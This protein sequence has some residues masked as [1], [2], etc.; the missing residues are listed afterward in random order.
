MYKFRQINSCTLAEEDLTHL[1]VIP[2][3]VHGAIF[4]VGSVQIPQRCIYRV[5]LDLSLFPKEPE[6][7]LSRMKTLFVWTEAGRK[8]RLERQQ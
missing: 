1:P 7:C 3:N 5:A 6:M 8:I 4:P 2:V